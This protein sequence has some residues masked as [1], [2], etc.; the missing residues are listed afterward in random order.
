[1][2]DTNRIIL[3]I[4]SGSHLYGTNNPDSDI[5]YL[6]VFIP[7]YF[8]Y[9][10]SREY[11]KELDLSIK[12]KQNNG[13][14]DKDAIDRKFYSYANFI[15]LLTENNPNILEMVF[16][17]KDNI[18][19][20]D[21][22]GQNLLN[23]KHLFPHKG[24]V[25][26]FIGYSNQQSHKMEIKTD[27]YNEMNI[28]LAYLEMVDPKKIV[29]EL[30]Y[31]DEFIKVLNKCETQEIKQDNKLKKVI[32]L[33]EDYLTIGDI[34]I[35]M[36]VYIKNAKDRI[37]TRLSVATN[38]NELISKYGYDCKFGA[39]L[40]RLLIEGRDFLK[41]GEIQFPLR[42]R[43]MILD[44]RNGKHTVQDIFDFRDNLLLEIAELEKT[45][46]LPDAPDMKKI[47]DF[48]DFEM[49]KVSEFQ[50]IYVS[51]KNNLYHYFDY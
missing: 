35:P 51:D 14:N 36:N 10:T 29:A 17:N 22:F 34:N 25:K 9:L 38:R 5:D 15:H 28:I 23:N 13:K 45:S 18:I 8:N 46:K 6:G 37:K 3:E 43:E 20:I 4:K 11:I 16:V 33:S 7:S 50:Y 30:Q 24:L 48:V 32:R 27:K 19:S 31:D 12:S 41:Y 39:H 21:E 2:N 1:M 47:F 49:K 40:V 26:R 44:I 42:D